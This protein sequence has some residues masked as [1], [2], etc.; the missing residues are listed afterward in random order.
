M[1]KQKAKE[2]Q[3]SK[4]VRTPKGFKLYPLKKATLIGSVVRPIGY[5]IALTEDGYK[6]YKQT[7]TIFLCIY[8]T[9][10]CQHRIAYGFVGIPKHTYSKLCN[11]KQI[12]K[13]ITK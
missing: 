12:T 5:K 1:A 11:P 9:G 6:F 10:M 4:A 13:T 8:N 7:N 2:Q 3:K